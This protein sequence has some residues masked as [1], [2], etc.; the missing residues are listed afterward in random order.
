MRQS[1]S[2]ILQCLNKMPEG[3]VK[4]DD[5]KIVPPS[6]SDMKA[7]EE[8]GVEGRRGEGGGGEEGGAVVKCCLTQESMEALIHHFKLFTEGTPVPPGTT[9]TAVEAPKVRA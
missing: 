8:R 1:L 5:A 7:S 4:I 9:Y 3:E 6:R 2:I